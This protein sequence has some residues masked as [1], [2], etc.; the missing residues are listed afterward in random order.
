[1]DSH[2]CVGKRVAIGETN[3]GFQVRR[4]GAGSDRHQRLDA[5]RP[6]AFNR[7]FAVLVELRIVQVAMRIDQL[8]F[9]RAPTG[10]SSWN[11][12]S[13]GLPPSTDAATII[14]LE[15][16]PRSLRGCRLATIT[17]LRLI[18]CSGL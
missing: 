18:N 3:G 8:H 15:V 2:G 9:R 13:T 11:P 10:I 6:G 7:L 12:A 1:M 4:A 17:T 16:S 14:P 5:G